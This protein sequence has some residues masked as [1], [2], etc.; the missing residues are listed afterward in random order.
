VSVL[1]LVLSQGLVLAAVGLVIG[2]GGAYFF[3]QLVTQFLFETTRTDVLVYIAAA[4]V[5]LAATLLASA[6]PA[7]RASCCS[8]R[9]PAAQRRRCRRLSPRRGSRSG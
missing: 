4:L 3:S 9:K 6:G 2:L 8:W 7:R 5:F 1:R